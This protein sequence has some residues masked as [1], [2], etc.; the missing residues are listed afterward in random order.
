[1]AKYVKLFNQF[2]DFLKQT[3]NLF[4]TDYDKKLINL[5]LDHFDDIAEVGVAKGKRAILI[6]SLIQSEGKNISSELPLIDSNAI[7]K[8]FPFTSIES[9]TVENF[10]GFSRQEIISFDKRYTFIYGP[11]GSG[12]S[13]LC[14]ALEYVM[15]GYINEAISKRIEISQYIRNSFTGLTSNPVLNGRSPGGEQIKMESDQSL[16]NF[17][18]I[19]KNRI[20]DFARIS[21]NT[22]NAKQSLLASLFGLNEFNDFVNNF[23]DNIEDRIDTKGKKEEELKKKS[24]GISVHRENIRL[25]EDKLANIELEKKQL[26]G[27]AML[28][29][30]FSGTD[31]FIH[32]EENKKGLLD[33]LDELINAPIALEVTV[34]KTSTLENNLQAIDR[35]IDAFQALNALFLKNRDKI[36]FHDLYNATIQI[37]ELSKDKCPVCETPVTDTL[38]HPYVNAAAKLQELSEIAELQSNRE[39]SFNALQTTLKAFEQL[40][41]QRDKISEKLSLAIAFPEYIS[42]SEKTIADIETILVNYR[43]FKTA[44]INQHDAFLKL[45]S[46]VEKYNAD[47]NE[48][49]NKKTAFQTE[50]TNLLALSKRIVAIKTREKVASDNIILWKKAIA[51]F[52]AVNAQLIKDVEEERKIVAENKEYVKAYHAFLSNLRT[53][54]DNLPVQH[55]EKLNT[56][57]LD[58]YNGINKHDKHFEKASNIHLPATTDD[59]INISFFNNPEKSYDVLQILSEGH[60]RCLGLA[61]LLAKNINDGCPVVIFDDVVNAIDDDHKGGVREV[62]FSHPLLSLKQIILTTHAEQF[63]KELEQHP[64]K[65]EYNKFVRKLSFMPDSEK[66]LIRIKS[67]SIKNYLLR[68]EKCCEEADWSEA[69]YN[70]R[71]SLENITHRLWNKLG[72]KYKTDFEV[73]IRSPNAK[74]DLMTVVQ[75]INKFLK[76]NDSANEFTVVTDTF[77]YLLGLETQSNIVWTYLNKGT[78][79]ELD[80]SEFDQLIVKDIIDKLVKLDSHV[81]G[82]KT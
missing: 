2:L 28:D 16:Y 65:D 56:L 40:L 76:N 72:K 24:E 9:L 60:I 49:K 13:S 4:Q 75:A 57:T 35:S 41:A 30:T 61:I 37:E 79:D 80:K 23:T 3:R 77:N 55:L 17:C 78:H 46:I 43:N 12:K 71:C 45:D 27:E 20:E 39:N 15:L 19:E 38:K 62:I 8:T 47:I 42:S 81:K 36:R 63:I 66:R 7:G 67:N 11:N 25:E 53:Y 58:L 44:F 14:E 50:R 73:V 69:L 34:S 70:C 18:F 64:S 22:P 5:I 21:A 6:N 68:A 1:M 51:D 10:R 48:R 33:E 29:I 26:C 59:I 54:K 32:G 74:P 82:K 31:V 52:N